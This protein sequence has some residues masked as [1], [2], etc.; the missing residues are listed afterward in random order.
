MKVEERTPSSLLPPPS[1]VTM[2]NGHWLSD[3]PTAPSD[4]HFTWKKMSQLTESKKQQRGKKIK[5]TSH[6]KAGNKSTHQI[7][8][9]SSKHFNYIN[10]VNQ[11]RAHTHTFLSSFLSSFLAFFVSQGRLSRVQLSKS[12]QFRASIM[13]IVPCQTRGHSFLPPLPVPAAAVS[14]IKH[15]S[16]K[17]NQ[18]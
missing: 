4:S 12:V 16:F 6:L 5:S 17:L 7:S 10:R 9:F 3:Y 18:L 1:S 13:Q 15:N 11:V 8:S 2:K 14:T